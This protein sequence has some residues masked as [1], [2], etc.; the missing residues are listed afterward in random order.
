MITVTILSI[1]FL[2]AVSCKIKKVK[3]PDVVRLVWY[4]HLVLLFFSLLC[5]LIDRKSVV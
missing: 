2:T 4:I 3:A 1:S 5:L